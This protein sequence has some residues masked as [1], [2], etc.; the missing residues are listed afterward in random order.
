[1]EQP[2][3]ETLQDLGIFTIA[4]GLSEAWSVLFVPY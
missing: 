2:R 1:V 4:Q 3:M